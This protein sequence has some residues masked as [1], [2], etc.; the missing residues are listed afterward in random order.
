MPALVVAVVFALLGGLTRRTARNF[1]ILAAAVLA[2][3]FGPR[4][5][6]PGRRRSWF[7]HSC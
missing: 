5:P 6:S 1:A 7:W 4:S 2:L 3:S